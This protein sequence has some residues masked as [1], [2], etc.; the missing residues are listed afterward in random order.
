GHRDL[1]FLIRARDF[2]DVPADLALRERPLVGVLPVEQHRLVVDGRT[3]R[4]VD[5]AD[6]EIEIARAVNRNPNLKG[7]PVADLEPITPRQAVADD[8][9]RAILEERSL[10]LGRQ[11]DLRIN[12]QVALGLDRK[13]CEEVSWVLIDAAEP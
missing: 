12:P 3:A 8:A 4:M 10:L 1:R 5:P 13:L 9:A 7:N 11:N 6:R 2:R